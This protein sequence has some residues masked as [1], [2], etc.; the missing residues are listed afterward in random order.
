ML[1]QAGLC[2]TCS[3]TT[4]LV[5]PRGGSCIVFQGS[6]E[7]RN[8]SPPEELT[9]IMDDVISKGI[10]SAKQL[11]SQ[12]VSIYSSISHLQIVKLFSLMLYTA[13]IIHLI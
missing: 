7:I 3:E 6:Q 8:L 4:L 2:R 1:V 10:E 11:N 12:Y 5:F 13:I 9:F